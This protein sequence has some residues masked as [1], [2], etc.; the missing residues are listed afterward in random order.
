MMPTHTDRELFLRNLQQSGLLSTRDFRKVVDHLT[1]LQNSR[2]IAR[3]LVDWGMVTKFQAELLLVG[4][5]RGFF[6]GPY[7]ILDH[8]GQGGMGRVYKALHQNM[9]RIVALKVLAPNLVTTPKAQRLFQ[10]EVQAAA[11][12]THPNIVTAFDANEVNGRHYLAMEFVDGP[13]LEHLVRDHGP[14]PVGMAC[15]II[16]QVA[17]GLQHAHEHGMIHRDIKPANL[18][19][20]PAKNLQSF[21]VK[22]LDFGL[23]RLSGPSVHGTA[24]TIETKETAVMGTPDFLSPEQARNLHQADIRSD[25]YS[26]GCTFYFL[27]TGKVP[28]PGG[29]TLEKLLRHTR[30][31]P[32]PI[33]AFRQDVPAPVEAIL[34]RLM[35]KQPEDRFQFPEEVA[36]AL[37]PFAVAA[38]PIWDDEF[39]HATRAAHV[40]APTSQGGEPVLTAPGD[41]MVGTLPS[42]LSPTPLS[43][44]AD[45]SL[46]WTDTDQ[47]H[48]RQKRKA[49]LWSIGIVALLMVTLMVTFFLLNR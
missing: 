19:L 6:L 4:R 29:A 43:N 48:R 46:P 47:D 11:R 35:A 36:A 9:N 21:V 8:L 23:A 12:L 39:R 17:G 25:L 34:Q 1:A 22:I 16:R 38:A 18:L 37:V 2:A 49:F 15:S 13:N 28:F 14:L 31:E 40:S 10:R 3:A 7:K 41:E 30:E 45:L 5:A 20:Q 32:A 27:L 44:S 33:G 42:D 24:G 26:L